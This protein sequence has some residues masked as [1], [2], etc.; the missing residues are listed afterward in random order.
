VEAEDLFYCTVTNFGTRM[1][2]TDWACLVSREQDIDALFSLDSSS[3]KQ[4]P[5]GIKR[6][7]DDTVQAVVQYRKKC[8]TY[9]MCTAHTDLVKTGYYLDREACVTAV[10][11][12]KR[13]LGPIQVDIEEHTLNIYNDMIMMK[14]VYAWFMF[15]KINEIKKLECTGCLNEES[16]QEGHMD[17]GCLM[18]FADA[19]DMY[20]DFASL[21]I[22]VTQMTGVYCEFLKMINVRQ[23]PNLCTVAQCAKLYLEMEEE[24]ESY[25]HEGVFCPTVLHEL[26]CQCLQKH[27]Q[28]MQK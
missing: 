27:K 24:V 28:K 3:E 12:I 26:F 2:V 21:E 11:K 14:R 10:E 1:T 25:V 13:Q 22:S 19:V 16:N 7:R 23:P 5:R 20:A 8:L 4:E 18:E 17:N 15:Q 6:K 9:Y